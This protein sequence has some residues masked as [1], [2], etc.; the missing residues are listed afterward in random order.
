MYVSPTSRSSTPELTVVTIHWSSRSYGGCKASRRRTRIGVSAA[1]AMIALV[2]RHLVVEAGLDVAAAPIAGLGV[3]EL[4]DGD[5]LVDAAPSAGEPAGAHGLVGL[6][7]DHPHTR[8]QKPIIHGNLKTSNIMMDADFQPR[9]S[10]FGLYLLLNPAAVQDMLE[11]AAVQGYKGPE[12][13]K[14]REATR[15]SDVYSLGVIM[16]EMLAQKEVAAND[17]S[18]K[19]R[20][21]HLSASFKDLI[22]ESKITDAFGSELIKQSKNSGN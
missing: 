20:D 10:D 4:D 12:L 8:S 19:A 13:I 11:V 15:E 22:L 17:G 2:S 6:E 21:I 16:L 14:M 5:G 9:V 3:D 18:P 7:L 1:L